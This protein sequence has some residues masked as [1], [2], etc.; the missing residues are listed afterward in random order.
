MD[1]N[2]WLAYQLNR[3]EQKDGIVLA[4]RRK[5]ILMNQFRQN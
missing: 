2:F 4:F 1:D 5:E 3:P